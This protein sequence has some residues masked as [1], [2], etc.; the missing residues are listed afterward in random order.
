[1]K[2][3]QGRCPGKENKQ[4]STQQ[5]PA[6]LQTVHAVPLV[7]STLSRTNLVVQS[8]KPGGTLSCWSSAPWS[9]SCAR[10]TRPAVQRGKGG[11][12]VQ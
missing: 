8:Y 6:I 10:G 11:R 1:M 2:G 3:G 12:V 9:R 4:I 5:Y 7:C